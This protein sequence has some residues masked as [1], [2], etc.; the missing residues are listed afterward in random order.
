MDID[1]FLFDL[2]GT[3]AGHNGIPTK[4]QEVLT[5]LMSK[6]KKCSVVTGN[7]I[8]QFHT[9]FEGVFRPNVPLVLECG[10][11]VT[12]VEGKDLVRYEFKENNMEAVE[13]YLIKYPQQ[14]VFAGFYP[15]EG[16]KFV[17]YSPQINPHIADKYQ[18]IIGLYTDNL[19]EFV[20]IM[21]KEGL[22]R[23][24]LKVN[25]GE[26][27]LLKDKEFD[28]TITSNVGMYELTD[29]NVSKKTGIEFLANYLQI[30]LEKVA[31]F[32]NGHNDISMFNTAVGMKVK[33]GDECDKLLA[34]STYQVESPEVLG[35]FLEQN[36]L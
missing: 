27:E 24:A 3:L 9:K 34:L 25:E 22:V 31:I 19:D 11:R 1:L 2:D 17:F 15:L 32:G 35:D 14:V 33:V 18:S 6:G 28:G 4:T 30:P 12:T 16:S 5:A 26:L 20:T 7:T 21:K 29:Q 13:R 36:F 23:M 8:L 10:G